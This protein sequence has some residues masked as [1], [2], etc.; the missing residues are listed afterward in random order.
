MDQRRSK[1]ITLF[2]LLL[3]AICFAL[4][5]AQNLIMRT[6]LQEDQQST[7]VMLNRENSFSEAKLIQAFD[8]PK[9][10]EL[11]K[12]G[13]ALEEKY[14]LLGKM[15]LS[16]IL[17][18]YLLRNLGLFIGCWLLLSATFFWQVREKR[19]IQDRLAEKTK[20]FHEATAHNELMLQ[21]S[22]REG[23]NLKSNI[24]DITHQLKTPV[25]SLKLSLDIALSEQYAEQ[26]RKKFA[27]QAEV[28]INKLDLMLDGLAK[29]SQLETDLIQ[30]RP[31]KLSLQ[32]LINQA[33]NSV[34]MKA[35]EKEMELEVELA[36]D[37]M[38]YVDEKWTLEALGNVLENAVKYAPEKTTVKVQVSSLVTYV[39][40]EIKDEGPGITKE[41]QNK[42]YQRFYRG[43]HSDSVE[44]SGVGLYL[45]R[46]IIEEQGGTIMVKR[47][48][49]KGANFQL[50]LPLA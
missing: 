40:V 1:K 46:K 37:R 29:I 33:V 22:Q 47:N 5:I 23:G 9:T 8:E 49:P 14:D 17:D 11:A 26:E 18:G 6:A 34:I 39:L 30:L 41:E 43:S 16:H 31:Q 25:A 28:Q 21:R 12:S 27:E 32:L 44:G 35:V 38:V 36:E 4:F 19:K 50:T 48:H 45:T 15:S 24:T 20:E 3:S 2:Y 13:Q 7:L 10:N 42:I